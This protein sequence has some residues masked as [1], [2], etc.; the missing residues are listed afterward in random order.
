MTFEAENTRTMSEIKIKRVCIITCLNF[1]SKTS[2]E[3]T[4]ES[5]F[6][7]LH[8]LTDLL[9]FYGELVECK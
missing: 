5:K 6:G 8:L 1:S 2:L 9:E 4:E 3:E 7:C